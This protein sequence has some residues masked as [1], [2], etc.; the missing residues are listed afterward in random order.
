MK[1]FT[2][3][4]R[5]VRSFEDFAEAVNAGF[6]RHIGGTWNGNLDAFNDFLSWPPE[7]NYELEVLGAETCGQHLGHAAKAA[8]LRA[9]IGT[10]HPSNVAD[11]KARLVQAESGEG[12]TLFEVILEI[13]ADNPQVRLVLR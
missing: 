3:D 4:G 13:V 6:V 9:H 5:A 7:T 12:E 10:C 1:A 8:W 11:M 2:I